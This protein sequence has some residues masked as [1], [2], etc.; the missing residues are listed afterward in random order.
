MSIY[1]KEADKKMKALSMT[2]PIFVEPLEDNSV[3]KAIMYGHDGLRME[4][5]GEFYFNDQGY[6]SN[7]EEPHYIFITRDEED[8]SIIRVGAT[9]KSQVSYDFHLP[10]EMMLN[11]AKHN[12][13]EIEYPPEEKQSILYP[14]IKN[15]P[16]FLSYLNSHSMFPISYKLRTANGNCEFFMRVPDQYTH[17]S[18]LDPLSL[19]D[20]ER[21]GQLDNNFHIEMNCQLLIPAPQEYFF[22]SSEA[23]DNKF[24][25]QNDIAGL[26]RFRPLSP[27]DKDPH[28]WRQYISTEYQDDSKHVESIELAELLEG[29]DLEKAMNATREMGISPAVFVNIILYNAQYEQRIKIDWENMIIYPVIQDLKMVYSQITIYVDLEYMNNQIKLIDNT[30]KNRLQ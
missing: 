30:E 13:F 1:L 14:R 10:Y 17:I 19:D 5:S 25:L 20:G 18:N 6:M 24:K 12:G 15:V 28:G 16:K 23:L 26:Y 2:P 27:P 7:D 21:E 3:I 29:T 4:L 8:P 22:Y 9:Q 11:M